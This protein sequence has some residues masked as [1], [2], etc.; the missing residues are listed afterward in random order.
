MNF[1]INLKHLESVTNAHFLPRRESVNRFDL[2][3][4]SQ[5]AYPPSLKTNACWRSTLSFQASPATL[6]HDLLSHLPCYN[7]DPRQSGTMP[8]WD[9]E[10]LYLLGEIFNFKMH[11][12]SWNAQRT[13][14]FQ[15]SLVEEK[16]QKSL[17][18]ILVQL[19]SHSLLLAVHD[20]SNHVLPSKPCCGLLM[21][22]TTHPHVVLCFT[23]KKKCRRVSLLKDLRYVILYLLPPQNPIVTYVRT[24]LVPPVPCTLPSAVKRSR[25]LLQHF[26]IRPS[27]VSWLDN[28]IS[29]HS[30]WTLEEKCNWCN[31]FISK[32]LRVVIHL[33]GALQG[34]HLGA[35]P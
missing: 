24:T 16:A 18:S 12:K 35:T 33:T 30:F 13:I 3:W 20:K 27:S 2:T 10:E 31:C 19:A 29:H 15:E 6:R 9:H 32:T 4:S 1:L 34:I 11:Q 26:L 17:H 7:W 14:H 23:K 5:C 22:F 8:S 21:T 25:A 28:H